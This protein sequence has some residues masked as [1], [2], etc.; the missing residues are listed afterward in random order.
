[1]LAS[2]CEHLLGFTSFSGETRV[3]VIDV[4]NISATSSGWL[5]DDDS[6]D[7]VACLALVTVTDPSAIGST[8]VKMVIPLRP[9][10][11][12]TELLGLEIIPRERLITDVSEI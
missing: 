10:E 1:M 5:F 3:I 12:M 6:G 4:H 11:L 7:R 9:S 2:H 8:N